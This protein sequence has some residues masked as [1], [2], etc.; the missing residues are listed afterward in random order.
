MPD[1][2]PTA[3]VVPEPKVR[4]TQETLDVVAGI[5]RKASTGKVEPWD[6]RR[7]PMFNVELV[8]NGQLASGVTDYPTICDLAKGVID[9]CK[10]TK[11]FIRFQFQIPNGSGGF[12][13]ENATLISCA[14]QGYLVF[15]GRESH[16]VNFTATA[17]Q[18]QTASKPKIENVKEDSKGNV[19]LGLG[20]LKSPVSA[21]IILG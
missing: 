21:G 1:T 9:I 10:A 20:Q 4:T 11:Y 18:A 13:T 5:L 3:V 12:K 6:G 19:D 8:N 2:N 16:K 17:E 7:G 15:A 14:P